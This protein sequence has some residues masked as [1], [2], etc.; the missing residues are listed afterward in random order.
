MAKRA[1][2]QQEL[3]G[4]EPAIDSDLRDAHA[5]YSEKLYERMETQQEEKALKTQLLAR[6][7]AREVPAIE[8]VRGKYKYV[9][10][11]ELG[12]PKLKTKRTKVG[13]D[14]GTED[15]SVEAE[16]MGADEAIDD[17]PPPARAASATPLRVLADGDDS[18]EG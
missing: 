17:D 9:T 18:E 1:R 6:M 13:E 12:E 2:K 8:T 3:P 7:Q 5:A 10:T 16:D 11:L 4:T 15:D 14:D